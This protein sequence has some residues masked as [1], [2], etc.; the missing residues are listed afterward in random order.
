MRQLERSLVRHLPG[1]AIKRFYIRLS[2]GVS[3]RLAIGNQ[4]EVRMPD[5]LRMCIEKAQFIDSYI[6]FF[7]VW[8]PIIT[9][10]FRRLLRPGDVVLDAGANIG[11]YTLLAAGRVGPRGRVHAIEAHP[12]TYEKLRKNVGLS[13]LSN[14]TLHPFAATDTFG[15]MALSTNFGHDPG[16]ARLM[17]ADC[18]TECITVRTVPLDSL[19]PPEDIRRTKLIKIDVE[20]AELLALRGMRKTLEGLAP[21]AALVLEVTPSLGN[22]HADALN[23]VLNVRMS[24]GDKAYQLANDYNIEVYLESFRLSPIIELREVDLSRVE[25]QTDVLITS[26]ATAEHVADRIIP[27]D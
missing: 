21:G 20:G 19:I 2:R 8:E 24:A 14:V 27:I 26:P 22:Y 6:Y 10:L 23:E 12:G 5:G 16:A 4:I 1:S 13:S 17:N 7:S 18:T 25:S 11:Y 3:R 15:S 9:E